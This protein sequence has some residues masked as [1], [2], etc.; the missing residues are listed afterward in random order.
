VK[1]SVTPAQPSNGPEPVSRPTNLVVP[2][3]FCLI[4]GAATLVSAG[5]CLLVVFWP[6]AQPEEKQEIAHHDPALEKQGPVA[7][8][9]APPKEAPKKEQKAAPPPDAE[10]EEKHPDPAL[11]PKKKEGAKSPDEE[12]ERQ[13]PKEDKKFVKE[14]PPKL[15]SLIDPV[16]IPKKLNEGGGD[17]VGKDPF[18][19][20][21]VI[22]RMQEIIFN[23]QIPFKAIGA[24]E[25]LQRIEGVARR[26]A[27]R[28]DFREDRPNKQG[29][30][31]LGR[32]RPLQVRR[33]AQEDRGILEP[34]AAHQ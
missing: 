19:K 1:R 24:M 34:R 7:K 4:L 3:V 29:R 14:L 33:M 26:P 2:F 18:G 6:P 12:P 21:L 5:F 8:P 11:P 25:A 23:R 28:S 22:E 15:E 31:L 10:T 9:A 32:H 17:P 20:D 13:D 27:G 30:V 16:Q